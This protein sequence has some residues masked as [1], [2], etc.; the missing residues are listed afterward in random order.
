MKRKL[1][2]TTSFSVFLIGAI[3]AQ[4]ITDT[5]TT[6]PSYANEVYYNL[7]SGNEQ[8]ILRNDWDL[9]FASDGIGFGSSTIRING[10]QGTELFLYG[11]D[12]TQWNLVDTTGFN[13]QSNQLINADT[14]WGIGA[15]NNNTPQSSFDLGWGT[16]NM[17]THLV[18][19][20]RIFILKLSSGAY[21]KLIVDKLQSSVYYF[22]YADL[23]GNNLVNATITKTN[24]GG[25]NFGYY[26]IQNQQELSR[27]PVS[28]S[29]D[30]LFTKYV[31]DLGGGIYYGVTGVLAN[32]GAKVA[33]V[34]NVSD[35]NTVSHVGQNYTSDIGT[36]GYD[37]KT[38]NMTTFQY[39]IED[40]LV[41]FVETA[42]SEIYKII[43]TGFGGSANGNYIFTKEL[44]GTVGLE[45]ELSQN[46]ILNVYPNPAKDVVNVVFNAS[47]NE[48]RISII[49][50]TGKEV[51]KHQLNLVIGL[52]KTTVS[53]NNLKTGVYFLSITLGNKVETQKLI[54]Q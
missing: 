29:W 38:F 7:Q 11:N 34:N 5:V 35:V 9:A 50:I 26:S 32:V 25:Q 44:V 16:Y 28:S 43:F 46:T 31:T 53:L 39:D 23:N 40:S 19:G 49:D 15:F 54:I 41:Y 42:N 20:D 36:I 2:F 45:E 13:W 24:H 33:Q 27:E 1:L 48:N 37:W 3:S 51:V 47:E 52:N 22:R 30:L 10:G 17:I 6:N 21:K 8:S 4:Q 14:S 12:T 18:E